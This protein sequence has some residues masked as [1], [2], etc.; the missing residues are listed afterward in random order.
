MAVAHP[1]T[2]PATTDGKPVS[3]HVHRARA[4]FDS[5]YVAEKSA[6]VRSTLEAAQ[7]HRRAIRI[8][9]V[10]R[11]LGEFRQ[12]VRRDWEIQRLWLE[13]TPY[14]GPNGTRWALPYTIVV[15]ESGADYHVGFAGA[16]GLLR[17]TWIYWGG[18]LLA[19]T[20]TAGA[21]E[22]IYQDIIAHK[23]WTEVGP[24]GW[25]CQA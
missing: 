22:P 11:K 6:P 25:E 12:K 13:S 1:D 5:A 18:G 9:H 10:R 2:H 3:F 19:G 21:A 15:C 20:A 16:Y 24:S 14:S 4:L 17:E 23:V 8:Q 7:A